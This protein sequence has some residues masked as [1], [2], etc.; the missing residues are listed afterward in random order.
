MPRVPA[1]SQTLDLST[2][3]ERASRF[4]RRSNAT[5]ATSQHDGEALLERLVMEHAR[6]LRR[7]ERGT[8]HPRLARGPTGSPAR[9]WG[10]ARDFPGK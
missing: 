2:F 7:N 5:D 9:T 1:S 8:P 10:L 4:G 3:D 6:T